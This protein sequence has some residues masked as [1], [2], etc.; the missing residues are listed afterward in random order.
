MKTT[1]SCKPATVTSSQASPL[2]AHQASNRLAN[3]KV[4]KQTDRVFGTIRSASLKVA[5]QLTVKSLWK[6]AHLEKNLLDATIITDHRDLQGIRTIETDH[7]QD[8][9]VIAAITTISTTIVTVA[10]IIN[11]QE[12]NTLRIWAVATVKI[13][14]SAVTKIIASTIVDHIRDLM[15]SSTITT[16]VLTREETSTIGQAQTTTRAAREEGTMN[17]AVAT[18]IT[19]NQETLG[20]LKAQ[21]TTITSITLEIAAV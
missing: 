10:T 8:P 15:T 3:V 1:R 5:L 4:I 21:E 13:M 17:A 11:S 12:A 20:D 7:L 14:S 16:K 18:S 6:R 9:T 19:V 2:R